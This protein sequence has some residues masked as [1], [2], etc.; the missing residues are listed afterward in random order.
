MDVSV[1]KPLGL[2]VGWIAQRRPFQRS[3]RVNRRAARLAAWL[4]TAVHAAGALH[5][6]A[7]KMAKAGLGMV[8][9]TQRRPFQRSAAI[10][11][12]RSCPELD[13]RIE[14][15]TAVHEL[16]RVHDTALRTL[17]GLL[18]AAAGADAAEASAATH[19]NTAIRRAIA[20][21][22]P[23][24]KPAAPTPVGFATHAR[25]HHPRRA[26]KRRGAP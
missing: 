4:P 19:A 5:E 1:S 8:S 10:R 15:S 17:D 16:G 20:Q 14:D 22:W 6:T 9:S 18:A 25:R 3:A 23:I 7:V 24:C 12:P 26:P 2:G 13:V 11:V 21:A